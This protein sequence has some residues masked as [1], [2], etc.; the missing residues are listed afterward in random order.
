MAPR[1]PPV[2]DFAHF[3]GG[4]VF[5]RR[6]QIVRLIKAGG[7]GAV[8]EAT[9]LSTKRRVAL[10]VMRPEIVS[11]AAER[12]RF[13]QEAQ[14]ATLIESAHVVDVLDA[15]VDDETGVPF[16]VMEFLVGEELGDHVQRR[17]RL[18][19]REVVHWLGQAAR[20]LDKAHARGV[21]H[22]DL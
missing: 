12:A 18:E 5:A 1:L 14:V 6:Y 17:G 8:Y 19:P 4:Q 13:V 9:H 15:G 16:L 22:R 7:M 20:A 21:I 3:A 2:P 11:D 10:K